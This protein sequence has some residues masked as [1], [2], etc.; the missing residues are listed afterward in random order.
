MMP[1][2][3][4]IDGPTRSGLSSRTE[5]VVEVGSQAF[6]G[7]LHAIALD[8]W[9]ADFKGVALRGYCSHLD[10]LARGLRRSDDRLRREVEGN[11]EDV[12]VFHIEQAFFVLI[13]RLTTQRASDDL[14]AQELRAEGPNS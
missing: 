14:L 10:R 11:A 13:I 9:E 7:Q 12:S 3:R 5:I 6:L 1:E 4:V 8:A 2:L